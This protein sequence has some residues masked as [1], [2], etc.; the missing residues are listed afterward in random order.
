M[1]GRLDPALGGEPIDPYRTA[2][3][4]AKRLF[5]GPLDGLG[6]R[7]LYLKMTLMEPP[8]FLALFNQP[9]PKLTTGKR[10]VTNVPDQA[11][12]LLNDPFVLAMAKHW[13]DRVLKD[14]A[15]TPEVR[16]KAMFTTALGRPP[17]DEELSR[18]V[19]LASRSAELHGLAPGALMA[20]GPVWHDVAHALFN[21]KEFIYVH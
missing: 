6:R 12:A 10:D 9:I 21:V 8:K 20:C 3:D 14:G 17:R 2:Q 7:S 19:K 13:G 18:L 16:A 4:A 11:L 5:S 1:S 15:A